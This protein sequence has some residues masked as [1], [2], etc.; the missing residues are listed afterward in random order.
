MAG[1]AIKALI[2]GEINKFH[3]YKGSIMRL[4]KR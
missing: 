3:Q 1:E 2:K 4:K